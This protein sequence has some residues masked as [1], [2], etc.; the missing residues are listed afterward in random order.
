MILKSSSVFG[1][2]CHGNLCVE[3]YGIYFLCLH[4]TLIAK[5]EEIKEDVYK[6]SPWSLCEL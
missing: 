6:I 5:R 3:V 4:Y 1:T 2:G